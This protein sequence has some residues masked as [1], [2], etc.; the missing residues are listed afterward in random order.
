MRAVSFV[1]ELT[2]LV[3][4]L[5]P[6]LLLG[7][8]KAAELPG[9]ALASPQP[10]P[11]TNSDSPSP[12][13]LT[14]FV[15]P[16]Q[17]VKLTLT[18][19]DSSNRLELNH[20]QPLQRWPQS[21]LFFD[22]TLYAKARPSG[23]AGAGLPAVETWGESFRLGYRY[24]ADG[25]RSF[26]GVNGGYDSSWQQG[27]VFQQL[28]LGLEAT[29][30]G[31]AAAATVT[32]GI[33]RSYYPSLG[34]SLLSSFNIQAAFPIGLPH[35]SMATRYYYVYDQLGQSAPGGQLQFSYGFNRSLSMTL[36]ASYDNLDGLGSSLQFKYLFH[37]P[38]PSQ[39]PAAVPYSIASPFSQAIGNTGS[40]IIR[41]SGSPPAYGD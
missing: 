30:P 28:G 31:L 11:T 14:G 22:N 5:V 16:V 7:G 18:P 23:E 1:R 27:Y 21:L 9:P 20:F 19:P 36:S 39:V 3:F 41:L 25:G 10:E 15:V 32:H 6:P 13:S 4:L 17:M 38:Q 2:Q 12:P 8:L 26:L 40:R 37:P 34:K 24:L 29:Y 33:G 35:L